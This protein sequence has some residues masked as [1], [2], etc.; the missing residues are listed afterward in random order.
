MPK[1]LA[2]LLAL[3]FSAQVAA[4]DFQMVCPCEV[5]LK[6]D[7]LAQ[8]SFS[9]ARMYDNTAI[10][11]LKIYVRGKN[12]VDSR[13][14]ALTVI[15]NLPRVNELESY[16]ILLPLL[17][18]SES[19][20]STEITLFA[21]EGETA[22]TSHSRVMA[23]SLAPVGGS[24]F[25]Y[26]ADGLA[27]LERPSY[28]VSGGSV[29][30]SVPPIINLSGADVSSL[31]V[32]VGQGDGATIKFLKA[33]EIGEITAGDSSASFMFNTDTREDWTSEGL[34][35]LQLLVFTRGEDGQVETL[36]VIDSLF[37][38]ASPS[39]A[40]EN[41]YSSSAPQIFLD[42]NVNGLSDYNEQILAI[43]AEFKT[44][45]PPWE[46]NV[47]AFITEN[48]AAV[49]SSALARVE[50]L[51]AHT[52]N[53]FEL[54]GVSAKLVLSSYSEVGNDDGALISGE[55]VDQLDLLLE[56]KAPFEQARS[57]YEDDKSDVIMTFAEYD[58]EDTACGVAAGRA[59]IDQNTF[60]GRETSI[61]DKFNFFVVGINCPDSVLAHEFGHIAGLGHSRVQEEMGIRDYAVG[62]GIPSEFVTIMPYQSEYG[63]APQIEL[64]SS[65]LLSQCGNEGRCGVDKANLFAGADAVFVL[66]QTVP[67][68]AAI[69]NGYPPTLVL[70]GMSSL[71]LAVGTGYNELG[72]R[73][74]D[75]EDGDITASVTVNGS[76]DSERVGSYEITYSIVDSDRNRTSVTRMVEIIP[77]LDGDG[78][79]DS[80]DEDR[81][82]D[83]YLNVGDI[84]PDD[85][86][87]WFDSDADGIGDNADVIY[88]PAEVKEFLLVN[89]MDA[90]DAPF[91]DD[92]VQW[93]IN[94]V[95][96][97]AMNAGTAMRTRLPIGDH[98][99]RIYLDSELVEIYIANIYS[100]TNYRGWGCNWDEIDYQGLLDHYGI[101]DD[102]DGDFTVDVEDG[103][104]NDRADT[105]DTDGD[106]V[107]NNADDDDD[108]DGVADS[109][110]AFPLDATETLDTD[111]DGLGNNADTDDD[112]DGYTDQ[113]ELDM[114][115]DP[116][117]SSDIPMSG[118]L[119]P[120]LLRVIS[121]TTI[122]NQ[123]DD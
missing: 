98:V 122:P 80:D 28:K 82:G 18:F 49:S 39:V 113:H 44:E 1:L 32:I 76:V 71:S 83:G 94:G 93:E 69:K 118:G 86:T 62:H 91:N 123:D 52:N 101:I 31:A 87:E 68:I 20:D 33:S 90:C 38:V 22:V 54:S 23:D 72:Y 57:F 16:T 27:F 67:H 65:P 110:D 112:N 116:L 89:R 115:S 10:D 104:P 117:D 119:S 30:V 95:V 79:A 8:V 66:N 59:L 78:I 48:A 96:S 81:D 77:D 107:G 25:S 121:E 45:L 50:H 36:H 35:L 64:F 41:S 97:S 43:P 26:R 103:L 47:S 42:S 17:G 111:G 70:T 60:N 24:G 21:M 12:E 53:I 120:A 114:G 84:F 108:G 5:E 15:D 46:V 29:E 51:F 105:V 75:V 55:E 58:D 19:Y 74:Y 73:A 106:G 34:N 88:E 14:M 63:S 100:T 102:S 56:F 2:I 109:D 13:V 9:L 40:L 3:F 11:S 92:V 61:S 6:S 4:R 7:S 99:F 85:P 37:D